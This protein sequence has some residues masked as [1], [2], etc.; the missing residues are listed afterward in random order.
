[1]NELKRVYQLHRNGTATPAPFGVD[2]YGKVIELAIL[3]DEKNAVFNANQIK[4]KYPIIEPSLNYHQNSQQM[5][6]QNY[7][8]SP[9]AQG[10]VKLPGGAEI[11]TVSTTGE[12]H[13]GQIRRGGGAGR[14]SAT[15]ITI[16]IDFSTATA[17]GKVLL[18][19]G[20][21]L[22]ENVTLAGLS[23]LIADNAAA[24]TAGATIGGTYK[25]YT[26]EGFKK[27]TAS[28][29]FTLANVNFQAYDAAGNPNPAWFSTP[30]QKIVVNAQ[31]TT[32]VNA[33]ENFPSVT[34][35]QRNQ[36]IRQLCNW[37]MMLDG[38]TGLVFDMAI[39]DRVVIEAYIVEIESAYV[40]SD[41]K[42][43]SC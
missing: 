15:K 13:K 9:A 37:D 17:A 7:N 3:P 25:T 21:G 42:Q 4:S 40:M 26:L 33:A 34:P 30:Y 27:L 43:G 8:C 11:S 12:A 38:L 22:I 2:Q 35:E 6:S 29:P 41:S 24:T 19:D 31:G 23:G 20:V 32:N 10:L 28:K 18:G 5:H 16:D 36:N 39:G 14:N 1:M